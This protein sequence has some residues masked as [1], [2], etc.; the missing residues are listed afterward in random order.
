M[1]NDGIICRTT[2][3]LKN[4][5]NGFFIQRVGGETIDGFSGE[6]HN[7]TGAEQFDRTTNGFLKKLRRMS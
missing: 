6:C 3:D 1:N 7:F 4:F 2:L 5:G